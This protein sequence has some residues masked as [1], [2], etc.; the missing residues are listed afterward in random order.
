MKAHSTVSSEHQSAVFDALV[1]NCFD[2]VM[3]TEAAP[4]NPIVYVNKAF[5][6]LTG[7]STE[8]VM[9]KSPGFLQGS[10]T[11]ASVLKRLHGDMAAGRVFEGKAVNYRKD[12]S[13]FTMWWRVIPVTDNS[14]QPTYFVAFQREAHPS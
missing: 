13:A 3:I 1:E 4:K 14:A 5:T 11:D 12:G 8:E 2:S 7:Y 10:G 6:D 9:G